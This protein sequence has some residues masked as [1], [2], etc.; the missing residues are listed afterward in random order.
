MNEKQKIMLFDD[1]FTLRANDESPAFTG[2]QRLFLGRLV[3]AIPV[4]RDSEP[5]KATKRYLVHRME[6]GPAN[7]SSD[8]YYLVNKYPN[9]YSIVEEEI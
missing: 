6:V 1:L 3:E 8:A 5:K 7:Q 2:P 9:E 4:D